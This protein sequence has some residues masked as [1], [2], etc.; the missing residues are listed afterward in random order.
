LQSLRVRINFHSN[1]TI[2]QADGSITITQAEKDRD[3]CKN[4]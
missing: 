4:S 3:G 2:F 1:P